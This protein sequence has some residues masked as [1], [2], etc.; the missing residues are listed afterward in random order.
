MHILFSGGGTLG[1]VT[2]LIGLIDGIKKHEPNARF[3]WVG[4]SGGPEQGF[5]ASRAEVVFFG[6]HAAKFRRYFSFQNILDIPLFFFSILRAISLLYKTKPD[7]CISAGGFVSVPVHVAAKMLGIPTWVHQQ[8]IQVGLANRI[9]APFAKTITV[10][11]KDLQKKFSQK[12]VTHIGNPVRAI[13]FSG[14]KERA[15]KNFSLSKGVPVVLV[16]GGG[17]GAV[18]LNTLVC[19]LLPLVQDRYQIVHVYGKGKEPKDLDALQKRYPN[20]RAYPFLQEEMVDA[21]V[22]ADLV[23]FRGGLGTLTE[24]SALKKPAICIPKPGHQEKNAEFFANK[25]AVRVASE[26]V[27]PQSL[28]DTINLMLSAKGEV[29]KMVENLSKTLPVP[30]SAVIFKI[31]NRTVKN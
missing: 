14:K 16:V 28:I 13:V 17:T 20:Y 21:Y 8:D 27:S 11:V 22:L 7:I 30:D 6:I 3:S 24:L 19:S 15:R 18:A 23:I 31:L 1:S 4:T 29:R 25:K 9:M 5:L 26:D 10:A 12:H 2:P